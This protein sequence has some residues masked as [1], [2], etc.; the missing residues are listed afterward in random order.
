MLIMKWKFVIRVYS[1]TKP[2]VGSSYKIFLQCVLNLQ[3]TA[4]PLPVSEL[5][6]TVRPI[7]IVSYSTVFF[8]GEVI[9][10]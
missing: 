6:S 2:T 7:N 5:W 9:L 1:V 10:Q 4:P 8:G 3:L